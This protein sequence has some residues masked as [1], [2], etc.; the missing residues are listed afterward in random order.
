MR[1]AV[2]VEDHR[3]LMHRARR[4]VMLHTHAASS[5]F[6]DSD[7]STFVGA[8]MLLLMV[9]IGADGTWYMLSKPADANLCEPLEPHDGSVPRS[10]ACWPLVP[11]TGA[12]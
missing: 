1:T 12:G 6:S 10:C 11:R 5:A 3:R 8:A 4:Y 7:V 9:V 2:D